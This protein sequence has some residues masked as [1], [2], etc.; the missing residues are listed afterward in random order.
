MFKLTGTERVKGF[1]S[2]FLLMPFCLVQPTFSP[3]RFVICCSVIIQCKLLT[4]V[5]EWRHPCNKNISVAACN[6]EQVVTAVGCEVFYLEL[7][8]GEI[9]Q[10][11]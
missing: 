6:M 1:I 11:R 9:K 8:V 7:A 3:F 2:A 5:S 4:V 10:I